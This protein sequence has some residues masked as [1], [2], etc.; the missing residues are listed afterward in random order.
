M[1]V[2]APMPI[3]GL[4]KFY[5]GQPGWG[6]LYVL[7]SWTQITRIASAVEGVWYLLQDSLTFD[8]NFNAANAAAASQTAAQTVNPEQVTAV[9]TA[10]RELDR[11]RQDGLISEY[12]FETKRRDLLDKIG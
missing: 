2:V 9:A 3:A 8:Q 11:L 7:L 1:G 4:H 12:E 6:V 5:L 10:L